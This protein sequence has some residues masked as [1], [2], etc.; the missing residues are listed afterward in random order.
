MSY[1][2]AITNKINKIETDQAFQRLE[3][4]KEVNYDSISQE[5]SKFISGLKK[6]YPCISTMQYDESDDE[7]EWIWADGPLED[8]I[9]GDVFTFSLV[10]GAL[11]D[12]LEYIIIEAKKFGFAVFSYEMEEIWWPEEHL[13]A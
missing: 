1:I 5:L 4:L 7:F 8:N 11:G 3:E 9:N 13:S 2:F 6:K 10:V 12:P